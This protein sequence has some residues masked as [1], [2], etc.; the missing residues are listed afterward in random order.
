MLEIRSCCEH[1]A[2]DLP[3]SSKQARICSYEC[4]FCVECVESVLSSVCPNCGGDF[5]PRPVRPAVNFKNNN[6]L[7]EHPAASKKIHRPVDLDAHRELV[8]MVVKSANQ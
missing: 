2:I 6:Y 7:G 4:T 5:Q 1:C 8:R 3:A